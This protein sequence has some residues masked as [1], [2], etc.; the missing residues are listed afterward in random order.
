MDNKHPAPNGD[1]RGGG[2]GAEGRATQD[3]RG[4]DGA[5]R[6]SGAADGDD[7]NPTQYGEFSALLAQR[8]LGSEKNLKQ[9]S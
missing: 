9:E 1:V 4:N 8:H 3:R 7:N 5:F 6:G 2:G